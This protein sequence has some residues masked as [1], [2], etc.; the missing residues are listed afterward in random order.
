VLWAQLKLKGRS[1]VVA[2]VPPRKVGNIPITDDEDCLNSPNQR[3][4]KWQ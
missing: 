2:I 1:I 3:Q 4:N